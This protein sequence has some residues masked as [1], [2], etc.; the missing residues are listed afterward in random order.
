MAKILG[1][2]VITA[3]LLGGYK[4]FTKKEAAAPA[5]ETPQNE[6]AENIE[7]EEE[8]QTVSPSEAPLMED[9]TILSPATVTVTYSDKGFSPASV[10][11][12][13]GDS[14]RFVNTTNGAMSVA[15]NPHPQHTNYS[16]FDQWKT[17]QQGQREFTFTFGK[18]GNWTYHNHLSP[19]QGGT[20]IVK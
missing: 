18:A 20:V 16:E 1:I 19:A 13:F 3:I 8:G 12:K 14:V 5:A 2:I 15:S 11:I 17:S 9:G 10:E 6:S 4:L 7:I